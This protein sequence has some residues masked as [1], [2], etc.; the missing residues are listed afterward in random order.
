M[1]F[2]RGDGEEVEFDIS[3]EDANW[4]ASGGTR[5]GLVPQRYLARL[6]VLR[7]SLHKSLALS[8]ELRTSCGAW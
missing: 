5:V 1:R 8:S 6:S 7:E 2:G 3:A 4:G